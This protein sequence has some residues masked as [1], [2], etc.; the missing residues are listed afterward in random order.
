MKGKNAERD[1]GGHGIS[2]PKVAANWFV[3][4]ASAL[5]VASLTAGC[6]IYPHGNV[7]GPVSSTQLA[8]SLSMHFY[9][10]L[11][12]NNASESVCSLPTSAFFFRL[13][14]V[15]TRKQHTHGDREHVTFRASPRDFCR[16]PLRHPLPLTPPPPRFGR[17]ASGQWI[18]RKFDYK[19]VS[20]V[21]TAQR[22]D[23]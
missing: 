22:R 13:P 23:I 12:S 19:Y 5:S 20:V 7:M 21:F 1:C 6:P 18:S 3:I 17:T 10:R 4:C 14:P 8:L 9:M 11:H 2:C 16:R 15:Y